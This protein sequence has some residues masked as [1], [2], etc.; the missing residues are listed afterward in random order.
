[1]SRVLPRFDLSASLPKGITVLESS[2]GTGK[3]YSIAHLLV[4]LVAEEGVPVE[5][6]LVVTFTRLATEE[7]KDRLRR[8]LTEAAACL[9]GEDA[10]D[11]LLQAW[12]A[13][14]VPEERTVWRRRLARAREGFDA[15]AIS[16]IHGFCQR[17]LQRNAFESGTRFDLTLLRD[18]SGLRDDAV[19]DW[20]T[21]QGYGTGDA[22]ADA[23]WLACLKDLRLTGDGLKAL[24]GGAMGDRTVRLPPEGDA[25]LKDWLCAVAAAREAA[26]AHDPVAA[27]DANRA[28]L[29]GKIYARH[30]TANRWQEIEAWLAGPPTPAPMKKER[31]WNFFAPQGFGPNAPDALLEHPFVQAWTRLQAQARDTAVALRAQAAWSLRRQLDTALERAYAQGFD[32][33]L[34]D[35]DAALADPKR[36]AD[37]RRLIRERFSVALIDEF[38]D[39]DPLQWRV[40]RTLFEQQ[41]DE[42]ARHRLVLIGDPKQAIYS[43][44]G[45]NVAVYLAA[46]A[47]AD[48]AFTMDRNFR[49]DRPLVDGLNHLLNQPGLFGPVAANGTGISYVPV[50]TPDREPPARLVSSDAPVQLRFLGEA[51]LEDASGWSK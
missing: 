17:M 11:P 5:Q 39:T 40:F 26:E 27:I 22:N 43:F 3:T 14:A 32:D 38:Q 45:A 33:L 30:H 2:A 46:R 36:G 35:L 20:L 49:S 23:Y 12:A 19:A 31:T 18:L 28:F 50:T 10:G 6:I 47:A 24:A 42:E 15:A 13:A 44:R 1:M 29:N 21:L 4:R 41:S 48:Q 7:L 25:T 8:R 16:T 9:R 34:V 37:L 51:G